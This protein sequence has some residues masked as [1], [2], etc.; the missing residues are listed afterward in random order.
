M[1]ASAEGAFSG[2]HYSTAYPPGIEHH[3]WNLARNTIIASALQ[4]YG[5]QDAILEI[6]CGTGVV[7][8]ALRAKGFD[9]WGSDLGIAKPA[10]GAEGFITLGQD[11]RTLDIKFRD[12]IKTLLLL[13]VIE[14]VQDQVDFMASMRSAF[15]NGERLIV[16]V[17]A[18]SELWSNYD[19]TY[20]HLR[21]YDRPMLANDLQAAGFKPLSCDYFFHAL[22]L[23]MRLLSKSGRSTEIQAP[24]GFKRTIH[25]LLATFC[26]TEAKLLPGSIAGTSLIAVADIVNQRQ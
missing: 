10:E 18:R 25:K 6:G 9:C 1:T 2:D 17:P 8:A 4:K 12:S 5:C 24:T 22:Y 16:T 13:D 26:I 19:D 11:C 7:V 20:G 23:P 15:P 21:R 3:F 14:H